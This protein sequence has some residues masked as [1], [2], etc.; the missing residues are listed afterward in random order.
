MC[1]IIFAIFAGRNPAANH[2]HRRR[3][4][5][6]FDAEETASAAFAVHSTTSVQFPVKMKPLT[7][8]QARTVRG[9]NATKLVK[10]IARERIGPVPPSRVV[11]DKSKGQ[12]PPKHKKKTQEME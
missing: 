1:G 4:R 9:L 5:V 2:V 10:E 6:P 11:P 8:K 7:E 12:K 3:V